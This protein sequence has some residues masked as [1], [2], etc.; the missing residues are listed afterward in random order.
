MPTSKT[1]SRN[2]IWAALDAADATLSNAA[3]VITT[4]QIAAA[5]ATLDALDVKKDIVAAKVADI[6]T[7]VKAV[8]AMPSTI[9]S[10]KIVDAAGTT[11]G[12]VPLYANAGLT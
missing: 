6:A 2:T 8:G 5:Q 9:K 10:V 11:V 3:Y 12:Y 7:V 4:A 1:L